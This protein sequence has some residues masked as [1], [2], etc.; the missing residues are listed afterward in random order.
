[1]EEELRGTMEN[2]VTTEPEV[3]MEPVPVEEVPA[4]PVVEAEPMVEE[5]PQTTPVREEVWRQEENSPYSPLYVPDRNQKKNNKITITFVIILVICLVCGMIFAVSKLVETAMGEISAEV[6]SWQETLDNW[7]SNAEDLFAEED[8]PE[9]EWSAEEDD[10]SWNGED[11]YEDEYEY[12]Y[13]KDGYVPNTQD[14]YY[15]EIVDSIRDDLSYT[16]EKHEY[17]YYDEDASVA[18]YVEYVSVDGLDFDN[19]INEA[20]EAGAMYYAK[21]F[22]SADVS[23]IMIEAVSYVTYMDEDTLSVVV[24]ERYSWDYSVQVDLYCMNFDLKTGSL[25]YNTNI[26]SPNEKLAE[27]FK[28]MSDYQNGYIEHLNEC[29]D[30]DIVD[31]LSDENNLIL[32]YTPVGL[33]VGFNYEDGWVTATIKDYEQ[34]LSKL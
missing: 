18:V 27:E 34:Y 8:N 14:E 22:A 31:Y 17:T 13:D 29:S 25:L 15:V 4:E 7:K 30:E 10:R 21:E 20:L 11:E 28:D 33:E 12:E 26:I 2:E 9:N 3:N 19:K 6:P 32:F 24:D 16:V 23:D 5:A 1:M